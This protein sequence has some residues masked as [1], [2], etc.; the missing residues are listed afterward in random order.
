MTPHPS[1]LGRAPRFTSRPRRATEPW[2]RRRFL[3]RAGLVLGGVAVGPALLAA[4]GD[5]GGNGGG[6]GGDGGDSAALRISNWPFYIDE[7]TVDLFAAATGIAVTYTEDVNSNDEYFAKIQEPLSRGQDIG[8]DL[9]VVTDWMAA[10]LIGLGWVAELDAAN[11]PNK[12]NL[13]A[14]LSSVGFDPDR[15][16]SLPWQSG[17]TGIIYDPE[18]AGRELTRLEDLFDPELAGRVTML[19]EM[20][21]TMGLM[22]LLDGVDPSSEFTDDD[23]QAGIDRLEAAR[24]S[25]Q[26]RRFTGNDYGDDLASGNVVAAMGWSG[27]AVQLRADAPNLRFVVP[28]EGG[29]LWSDN[30]MIPSTASAGAKANAERWMDYCYDPENMA[31]I[32]EYVAFIPPVEGTAAF[33]SEE[34]ASDPLVNPPADLLGRLSVFR[35]LDEETE[36]RYNQLFQSVVRA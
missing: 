29:M 7:E 34:L 11:V 2:S 18:A 20:R 6:T 17:M 27:D 35:E 23:F 1:P 14:S 13:V 25:G 15:A 12:A 30:M 8:A 22:L 3:G 32:T 21:D 24:D 33:L 10:R 4:C 31:R 36:Q 28:D 16:Y 5:D 26:I 19:T 9:F